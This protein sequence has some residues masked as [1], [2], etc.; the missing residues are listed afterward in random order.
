MLL[1]G[2]EHGIFVDHNDF[3]WVAGN[4]E[5]RGTNS[6]ASIPWAANF[7]GNDSQILK[8]KPDGTFIFRRSARQA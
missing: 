3:V 4:G 7:G 8:F 1:A 6:R 5:M 2:R